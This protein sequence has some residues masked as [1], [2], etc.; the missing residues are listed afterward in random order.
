TLFNVVGKKST[1]SIGMLIATLHD[2]YPD[3]TK[4]SLEYSEKDPC[5]GAAMNNQKIICCGCKPKISLED[6]I[7]MLVESS[8]V[9]DGQFVFKDSYQG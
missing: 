6:A 8:R 2:I 9:R 3:D 4:V 1:V 7:Q 5:Y